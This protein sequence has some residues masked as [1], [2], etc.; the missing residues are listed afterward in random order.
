MQDITFT[1]DE[2][3]TE[4]IAELLKVLAKSNDR[5]SKQLGANPTIY[6]PDGH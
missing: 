3:S 1:P 4:L 2:Q 5:V 6:N